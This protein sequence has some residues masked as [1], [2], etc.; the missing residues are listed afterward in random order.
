MRTTLNGIN[1]GLDM[2]RMLEGIGIMLILM[3]LVI[4]WEQLIF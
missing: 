3:A 1:G 4:D 2:K